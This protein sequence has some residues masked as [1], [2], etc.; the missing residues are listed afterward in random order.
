MTASVISRPGIVRLN[1]GRD[2]GSDLGDRIAS[3]PLRVM[4]S[5]RRSSCARRPQQKISAISGRMT[6]RHATPDNM[7]FAARLVMVM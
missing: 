4:V 5:A 7:S 2:A 6:F 1:S 3:R